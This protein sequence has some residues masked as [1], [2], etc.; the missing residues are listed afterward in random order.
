MA[1][2]LSKFQKKIIKV[3]KKFNCNIFIKA[4]PGSGKTFIITQLVKMTPRYKKGL[5]TAFN[6]AIQEDLS[7]KI[8][9]PNMKVSTL[10]S[11]GLSILR[12]NKPDKYKI[13]S[14]KIWILCKMN[15]NL[16]VFKDEGERNAHLIIVCKL[17][18]LFR[19]NLGSTKEDLVNL[20]DQYN[21]MA[22]SA[23]I[24]DAMYIVEKM[25]E[26][27]E[28]MHE[29]F[30]IDFVDMIY[31]PV[32]MIRKRLFPKYDV[33]F[34]DEV[35]DLNP[36]QKRLVDNCIKPKGRFIAVGDEKQAIYSFMGSNL[37]SFNE[38]SERE[39]TKILPLSISYRCSKKIVDEAN[40]VFPGLKAHEE[41]PDGVVRNGD[42]S[43]A[44]DGDFI[45]CRNNLPLVSAFIQLLKQNKKC[46][47]MGKDYGT[48]LVLVL[49]KIKKHPTF[50]VGRKA[51]LDEV[52]EKLK[53]KGVTNPRSHPSYQKVFERTEILAILMTEFLSINKV[54]E[55]IEE[56]FSD[57][58]DGGIRLST[59][60]KSKGLEADK[61]FFLN[62]ELI[63][64]EYA[65]TELELYQEK[66][67][68][69]VAVTRAI[70]ELIYCKIKVPKKPNKRAK[71]IETRRNPNLNN[72]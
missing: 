32:T 65:V 41:A 23:Q 30:M 57:G 33:V 61:I 25:G 12:Y 9:L 13:T 63:P 11:L 46:Y 10:H 55:I 29:E 64:S 56:L 40:K 54:E 16:L 59:I 14:S 70:S 72:L 49:N 42:L 34:I 36:L 58:E 44:Q 17:V 4:G 18:D 68:K 67:L 62:R 3:Y 7:K 1:H 38:F 60:H 48:G 66:C 20:S 47:I 45:I 28:G 21:V 6:K 27:N 71:R 52:K 43:E 53:E 8:V 35:Q 19:M 31:L 50:G 22:S 26:Y 39:D 15:L 51:V 2:K 24:N 69:F 5:I 37:D